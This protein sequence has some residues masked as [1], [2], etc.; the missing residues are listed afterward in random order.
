MG[1]ATTAGLNEGIRYDTTAGRPCFFQ[2][3]TVFGC[4]KSHKVP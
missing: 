3:V 2:E 1:A 4:S